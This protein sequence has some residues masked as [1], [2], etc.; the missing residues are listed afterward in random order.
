MDSQLDLVAYLTSWVSY[1]VVAVCLASVPATHAFGLYRFS[2]GNVKLS[3]C[4]LFPFTGGNRH[5]A[6]QLCS[7]VSSA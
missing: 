5:V 6:L 2:K 4:L 1:R 7:W 3:E